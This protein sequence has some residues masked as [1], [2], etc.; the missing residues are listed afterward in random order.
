MNPIPQKLYPEFEY[1]GGATRFIED[2]LQVIDHI[3]LFG[4]FNYQEI[5]ALCAYM[6]CYAAPRN[7]P[8]LTE[9]DAGGHL[10]L[11]L[12]GKVVVVKQNAEGV[13]KSFDEVGPG[14]TLGEMS[15]IDGQPRFASCITTEPTDFAVLTRDNLNE[16]FINSPRLGNKLLLILLQM[17]TRRLRDASSRLL[18][19]IALP[20]L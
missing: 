12:T 10:V 7:A 20:A 3:P 19:H 4:D 2:I 6:A 5:E 16:I 17:T 8:L 18:P 14:A 11:L 1:L 9:G 13:A 15:M